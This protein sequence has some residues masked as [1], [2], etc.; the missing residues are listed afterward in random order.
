MARHSIQRWIRGFP[1]LLSIAFLLAAPLPA[2]AQAKKAAAPRA[3]PDP[4]QTTVTE[5]KELHMVPTRPMDTLIARSKIGEVRIR[6]VADYYKWWKPP[7]APVVSDEKVPEMPSDWVINLALQLSMGK[8]MEKAADAITDPALKKEYAQHFDELLL[9]YAIPELKKRLIDKKIVEPTDEEIK[10]YYEQHKT[11][12]HQPFEF[13]MRHIFMSTYEK[14][15]VKAGDTLEGIAE[16]ISGDKALVN[17]IRSDAESRP[18]RWVPP[19]A[20]DKQLFKPLDPGE[21]L[22]VPMNPQKAEGVKKRLEDIAA[23]IK[24]GESKFEQMAVAFSETEGDIKGSVIGPLPTGVRPMLPELL[25]AAKA[26]QAGGVSG[27]FQTKHGFNLIQVVEKKDEGVKPLDQVRKGPLEY[28]EPGIVEILKKK[29]SDKL[30]VELSN[31]L[32]AQPELKIDDE[33][34]AKA[35]NLK[36]DVVLVRFGDRGLEWK[37]FKDTWEKYWGT[38]RPTKEQFTQFMRRFPPA[39]YALTL[40]WCDNHKI[41][42]EPDL[43]RAYAAVRTGSYAKTYVEKEI[44]KAEKAAANDQAIQAYYE[45]HKAD[46]FTMPARVSYQV[47]ERRPG[48]EFASASEN[49]KSKIIAGIKKDLAKDVGKLETIDD[50]IGFADR[51][52]QRGGGADQ[53]GPG[54]G[55]PLEIKDLDASLLLGPTGEAVKKVKPGRWSEPYEEAGGVRAVAVTNR[56]EPR[57]RSLEEAKS[58][59][60]AQLKGEAR[61]KATY[62]VNRRIIDELKFEKVLEAGK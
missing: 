4:S 52:N 19:E 1:L 41:F 47:V 60:V 8:A 40:L 30:E 22:L 56:T 46:R 18:L 51:V 14:Y 36:D 27:V 49:E 9:N 61:E 38:G 17:N 11:E 3:T 33:A 28:G 54:G 24:S 2:A 55:S 21:K 44:E 10:A 16:Q 58:D 13:T 29:Q 12:Y 6:D 35:P 20:R 43:S 23:K 37:R 5:T 48:P 50:F 7:I 45:A 53:G 25:A 34:F 26:A 32:F 42:N 59:I 62:A 31:E 15:V 57:L 39:Q